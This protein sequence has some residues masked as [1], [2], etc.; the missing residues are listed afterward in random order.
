MLEHPSRGC[1][2]GSVISGRSVHNQAIERLWRDLYSGCVCLF[3]S[4]FY[5]LEDTGLLNVNN[6]L[7]LYALHY[8]L[9]L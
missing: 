4:L 6:S 5:F 2:R 8:V 1:G 3:Y 7:D 9:C